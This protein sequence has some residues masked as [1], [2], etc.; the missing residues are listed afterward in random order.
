MINIVPAGLPHAMAVAEDIRNYD[1]FELKLFTGM[2]PF[3][4]LDFIL[5]KAT[6]SWV[7]VHDGNPSVI[8][9]YNV[10]DLIHKVAAPFM[11]ATNYAA[12]HPFL[13]ARHSETVVQ[14]FDGYYLVN[15]VPE[16]NRLAIRW[17]KWLG[18]YIADPESYMGIA[19]V[20]RFSRDCR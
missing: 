11:I 1:A 7:V 16:G 17:L 19:Q 12:K 4:A 8:F 3:P 15:Y 10:T 9:G 5:Q 13:F 18:F 14:F 20:R 2:E 6:K